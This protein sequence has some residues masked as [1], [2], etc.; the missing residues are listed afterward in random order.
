VTQESAPNGS[1][2]TNNNNNNTPDAASSSSAGPSASAIPRPGNIAFNPYAAYLTH[3]PAVHAG[4][5]PYMGLY[6]GMPVMPGYMPPG[7]AP[8]PPP[9]QQHPPHPHQQQQQQQQARGNEP[10]RAAKPKRLKAHTVTSKSY[11]IP[12]VPRDKKGG[13]MLPLNVG[14][15][16]VISLGDVCMREHFHTERY[17]FPVGYEVTRSVFFLFWRTPL[18]VR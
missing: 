17:I 8:P 7:F 15:M 16:T 13:P 6:M 12:M 2:Y 11:S 14:I 5:N 10:P 9:H 3:N 18:I 4:Y 1:G